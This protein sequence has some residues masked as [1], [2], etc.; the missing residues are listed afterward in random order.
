[1]MKELARLKEEEEEAKTTGDEKK[2]SD[3]P[4]VN[5][6]SMKDNAA[7]NDAKVPPERADSLE[8]APSPSPDPLA[9]ASTA[10]HFANP[11]SSPASSPTPQLSSDGSYHSVPDDHL[12]RLRSHGLYLL[13]V[14]LKQGYDLAARD[15]NGTSDPY[16]KF[17]VRGKVA[18]KSKTVYKDLNPFWDEHF[19]I[20]IEDPF[21][22]VI[23][24]VGKTK[25]PYEAPLFHEFFWWCG[26]RKCPLHPS[27][28][29]EV[30]YN[31]IFGWCISDYG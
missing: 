19:V 11:G 16:V 2:E 22:P 18:H 7:V 14:H 31:R 20:T 10:T 9:S 12:V 15:A 27:K 29:F 30:T 8:L 23:L 28:P 21:Q 25:E 6:A 26:L 17:L 13:N 3:K 24:K 4:V 1:M 5:A